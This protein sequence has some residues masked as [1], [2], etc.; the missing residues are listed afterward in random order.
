MTN[1]PLSL[2][3]TEIQQ[4]ASISEV[5]AMWGATNSAEMEQILNDVYAVKFRFMNAAPGYGGDLFL[6]QPDQLEES[7]PV[8]RLIRKRPNKIELFK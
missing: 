2:T 4:I 3:P 1:Q 5:Q 8:I 7:I 6:I